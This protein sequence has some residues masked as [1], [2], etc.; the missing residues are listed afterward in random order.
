MKLAAAYPCADVSATLDAND[1]IVGVF[2]TADILMV[3]VERV[4]I[5]A[6]AVPMV[7]Q[8]LPTPAKS[9]KLFWVANKSF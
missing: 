1:S 8:D 4:F 7:C 9:T 5:D 2:A 6:A 3:H